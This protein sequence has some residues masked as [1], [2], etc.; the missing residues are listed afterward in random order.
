MTV[1]IEDVPLDEGVRAVPDL[2][3]VAFAPF[4]PVVMDVVV[5]HPHGH[6]IVDAIDAFVIVPDLHGGASPAVD[7]VVVDLDVDPPIDHDAERARCVVGGNTHLSAVN[8]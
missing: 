3:A 5:V 6:R 2:H 7:L 1:P 4:V 8:P